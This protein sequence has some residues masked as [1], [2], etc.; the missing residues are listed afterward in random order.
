MTSKQGHITA[1]GLG[2]GDAE[3]ITMKGYKALQ[4]ADVIYYPASIVKDHSIISFSIKILNDLELITP[5]KAMHFPM[6][7]NDRQQ[8]YINAYSQIKKDYDAG[9]KIAIV[10]EGD[11]L[12]YSTFGYLLEF[13]QTD[14]LNYTIIP[15][16]PAFI[17]AGT[18]GEK[19]LIDGTGSIKVT[20]CPDSFKEIKSMLK[21]A[22]T[23]VL[24]KLSKIKKW[25]S[26]F[27]ELDLSFLYAEQ[28]GTEKQ[29]F[30]RNPKDIIGREIPY[31]SILILYN[32]H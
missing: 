31:F 14:N 27:K 17:A 25:D 24:M 22:N 28:I 29:F 20:A 11:V 9:L 5:V 18:F 1:V 7:S 2:P 30:T 10:S 26:F 15:G 6:S 23:L 19:A 32:N 16:V 12:F 8:N 13:I 21:H 3:L 4:M